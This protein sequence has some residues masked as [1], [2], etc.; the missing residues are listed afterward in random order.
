MY[1]L[2]EAA[3]ILGAI[4]ALGAFLF[5]VSALVLFVE[6]AA[7]FMGRHARDTV[8]QTSAWASNRMKSFATPL[9][10]VQSAKSEPL[11]GP[12]LSHG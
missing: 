7:K 1:A 12:P 5:V 6:E 3:I 9:P 10:E 11:P 4:L 2:Y 8:S